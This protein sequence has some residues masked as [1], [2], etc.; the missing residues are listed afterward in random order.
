MK[1]IFS[2]ENKDSDHGN[3]AQKANPKLYI[4]HNYL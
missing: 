3:F 4:I 1:I 2:V